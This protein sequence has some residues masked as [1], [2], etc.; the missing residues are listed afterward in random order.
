MPP[1]VVA[2]SGCP[3]CCYNGCCCCCCWL[4]PNLLVSAH[5]VIFCQ[6]LPEPDC[7][8]TVDVMNGPR[9]LDS[10]GRQAIGLWDGDGVGLG[11]HCGD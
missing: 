6:L 11:E 10:K 1:V 8:C 4:Q 2:G 7:V 5:R 3:C 9:Y